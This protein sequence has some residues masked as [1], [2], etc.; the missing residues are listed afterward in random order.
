M[1]K[2][3]LNKPN[4]LTAK[5]KYDSYVF[6]AFPAIFP[7]DFNKHIALNRSLEYIKIITLNA[8]TELFQ[9]ITQ[10]TEIQVDIC[11]ISFHGE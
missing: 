5:G 1:D 11:S 2:E 3:A 10:T 6:K 8:G 7:R 9:L 4:L